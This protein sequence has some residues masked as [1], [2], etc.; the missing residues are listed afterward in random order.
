MKRRIREGLTLEE[1]LRLPEEKPYLEYIDG[2][3]ESKGYF[4]YKQGILLGDLATRLNQFAQPGKLGYAFP[5][6]NCTFAGWSIVA[7]IAYLRDEA[8]DLDESG[9]VADETLVRPDLHVEIIAVDRRTANAERTLDYSLAHGCSL[10]WLIHPYN[11]TVTVYR[12]EY[13]PERLGLD[14]TLDGSNLLPGFRLGVAELFGR[15]KL[16]TTASSR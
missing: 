13:R 4:G 6:L 14:G 8:I 7:D 12:P 16:W 1:F 5:M 9:E 11:K 15:L 2:R 10:G 3:V